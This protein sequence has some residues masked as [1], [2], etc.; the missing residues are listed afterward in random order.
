MELFKY[1]HLQTARAVLE[2]RTLRWSSPAVLNDPA[3]FRVGKIS[4]DR[5]DELVDL[6]ADQLRLLLEKRI[7][8]ASRIGLQYRL[9]AAACQLSPDDFVREIRPGIEELVATHIAK[10]DAFISE[11][12]EI[13]GKDKVLCLTEDQKN[14]VMWA[15]YGNGGAGVVLGFRNIPAFD[16]PYRL[17]KPIRY[18]RERPRLY[19]DVELAGLIA[20][21]HV[22]DVSL[23]SDRIVFTKT[24]DWSYEKE[25]RIYTAAGRN[26]QSEFEDVRFHHQELSKIIFGWSVSRDDK[27]ALSLFAHEKY[28]SCELLSSA[29]NDEG[30]I[31]TQ[32]FGGED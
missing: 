3:E 20:G 14:P 25:W 21:T 19:E 27:L 26:P 13:M 9:A 1:M 17:A 24:S 11:I 4:P 32:A 28:D 5:R 15:H 29:L 8:P 10:Q 16:S 6:A 18:I 22:T 23:M 2:N 7:E 31:V 30:K 12:Y